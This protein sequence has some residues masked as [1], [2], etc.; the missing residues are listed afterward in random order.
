MARSLQEC[1]VHWIELIWI[2]CTTARTPD[3]SNESWFIAI[4]RLFFFVSISLVC[5]LRKIRNGLIESSLHAKYSQHT[6]QCIRIALAFTK[7]VVVSIN[8]IHLLQKWNVQRLQMKGG[9]KIGIK[10]NKK[11]E[12][13]PPTTKTAKK[14]LMKIECT[15]HFHFILYTAAYFSPVVFFFV[16]ISLSLSL[17]LFFVCT[18]WLWMNWICP[19]KAYTHHLNRPMPNRRA[20]AQQL[21]LHFDYVRDNCKFY[22]NFTQ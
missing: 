8:S 16:S 14:F 6:K 19:K 7:S 5:L 3:K 13:P 1:E 18:W 2:E 22:R 17:S 21:K 20:N 15:I 10:L 12:A 11:K 9:R 4:S